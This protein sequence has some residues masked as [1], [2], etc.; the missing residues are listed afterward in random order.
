METFQHSDFTDANNLNSFE[1]TNGKFG[2][3]FGQIIYCSHA[4]M[5]YMSPPLYSRK[6]I[7]V[8]PRDETFY[9]PGNQVGFVNTVFGKYFLAEY[10]EKYKL[11]EPQVILV[12]VDEY[13]SNLPLDIGEFKCKKIMILG[14]THHSTLGLNKVGEYFADHSFDYYLADCKKN[15][16]HFFY[17]THPQRNYVFFPGF[18]NRFEAKI[19]NFN[20]KKAV[21][22]IGQLKSSHPYRLSIVEKLKHCRIPMVISEALQV[23]AA[24]IYSEFL[25][26]INVSLNNEFNMRFIEVI[27][28]GG[29]L[30][31]DRISTFTGYNEIFVENEDFVFYENENDLVDKI[32]YFY[33]N[34]E[35][36]IKI[37]RSGWGK[38]ISS[39][40]I[41]KRRE[42]FE[43]L[44]M[45]NNCKSLPNFKDERFSYTT[46]DML[47]LIGFRKIFYGF[48]QEINKVGFFRV[49]L[50]NH[51]HEAVS[52]D[53]KDLCRLEFQTY[54]DIISLKEIPAINAPGDFP[55]V[56]VA[57]SEFIKSLTKDQTLLTK[58]TK[59]IKV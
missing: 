50:P 40:S 35:K 17:E 39:L 25:I 2:A 54:R 46:K 12:H 32:N 34:P 45:L 26:N 51:L 23:Q 4:R 47:E 41:K 3:I 28:A 38:F 16:L 44:I 58:F 29:F 33:Q 5:Q 52:L 49:L 13:Q 48:M 22:L 20:K 19:F 24:K 9:S 15:H 36:A 57:S 42:Q 8:G 6:Q 37:A 11:P 18:R 59:I 27:S 55:L 56:L 1:N 10:I 53:V 14:D 7:F 21:S 43:E 30:L 31:T